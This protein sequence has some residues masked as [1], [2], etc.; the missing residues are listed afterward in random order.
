MG[1]FGPQK[2]APVGPGRRSPCRPGGQ[3]RGARSGR[4]GGEMGGGGR[5][6]WRGQDPGGAG[7]AAGT[8]TDALRGPGWRGALPWRAAESGG[9]RPYQRWARS[10]ALGCTQPPVHSPVSGAHPQAGAPSESRART[11]SGALSPADSAG[12]RGA[13]PA[14]HTHRGRRGTGG[15]QPPPSAAESPPSPG[16]KKAAA[17]GLWCGGRGSTWKSRGGSW[18][19][20]AQEAFLQFGRETF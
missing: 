9:R 4:G 3:G 10:P 6:A 1:C 16:E 11:P 13:P 15:A 7:L 17:R 19:G 5:G 2:G 18:L 20:Q 8:R 12:A 14:G